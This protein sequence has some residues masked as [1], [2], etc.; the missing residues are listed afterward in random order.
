M[1]DFPIVSNSLINRE[2]EHWLC[3][4]R[5]AVGSQ[6]RRSVDGSIVEDMGNLPEVGLCHFTP[7][8]SLLKFN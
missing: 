6:R 1:V 7:M 3:V 8:C 4:D 5:P 2:S